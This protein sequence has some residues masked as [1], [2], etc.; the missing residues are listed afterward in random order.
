MLGEI[1]G[2]WDLAILAMLAARE[3]RRPSDLREAVNAQAGSARLSW[4]V[5]AERLRHLEDAGYVGRR[6]ISKYPRQTLYWITPWARCLLSRLD[7][8]GA[9]H[10]EHAPP[11]AR[12]QG[13]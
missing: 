6:E 8:L 7:A 5:M 12:R 11:G 13:Y 3:S 9:W 1:G 2:R 4:K 10:A